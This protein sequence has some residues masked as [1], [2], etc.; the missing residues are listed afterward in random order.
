[1]ISRL[2]L[3]ACVAASFAVIAA[4]VY[5]QPATPPLPGG[6]VIPPNTCVK[7][8]YP[9][10]LAS[11][12]K[13]TEFNKNYNTYGECIKKYVDDTKLIVNAAATAVNSAVEDFNKFAAEVKTQDE[14]GKN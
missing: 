3:A 2:F 13:F 14:A 10:K 9:G 5:A 4:D 1:M 11:A 6:I 7:P 8:Q 12:Q